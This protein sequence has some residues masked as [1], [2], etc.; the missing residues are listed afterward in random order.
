MKING[1][2]DEISWSKRSRMETKVNKVKLET[3]RWRASPRRWM[4]PVVGLLLAFGAPFGLLMVQSVGSGEPVDA[5]WISSELRDHS[6]TYLYLL[7]ST[8]FVFAVLGYALGTQQDLLVET[9]VTDPLTRLYNRRHM[10]DRL[11]EEIARAARHE[12]PFALILIDL[13]GLKEINDLHGHEAGDIALRAVADSL[14]K[15]CRISDVAA[16]F[17]G[18]EF[19]VLAPLTAA[20]EALKL[21]ERI[22]TALK[23]HSPGAPLSVSIGVADNGDGSVTQPETLYATADKALYTAKEGGKDRAVYIA[24]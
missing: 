11:R 24:S 17:G 8:S 10:E 3:P 9:A 22:R 7:A 13:D 20:P 5:E 12:Q 21:A 2:T 1:V 4:Y 16:R 15:V 23:E 6:V 19:A 14:R 18:D